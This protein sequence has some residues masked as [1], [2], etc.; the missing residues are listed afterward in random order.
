[1]VFWY[2]FFS[3]QKSEVQEVII[4]HEFRNAKLIRL[5]YYVALGSLLA[6]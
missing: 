3:R 5:T 6:G 1:M 2:I 4:T